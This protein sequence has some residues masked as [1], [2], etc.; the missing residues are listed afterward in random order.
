VCAEVANDTGIRQFNDLF[1]EVEGGT[2]ARVVAQ[3]HGRMLVYIPRGLERTSYQR[4]YF[5]RL[6][7]STLILQWH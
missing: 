6:V 3:S 7:N 4:K 5:L 2:C 1:L